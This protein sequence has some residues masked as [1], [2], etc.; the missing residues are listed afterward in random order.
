MKKEL[1]EKYFNNN[2][3]EEELK[4]VLDWFSTSAYLPEGKALLYNM[5]EEFDEQESGDKADFD[6]ILCKIHHEIN[7][8]QSK[9]LIDNSENDLVRY[10]RRQYFITL[11]R[12]VAAILLLPV[13]GLGLFYSV[14]YYSAKSIHKSVNVAFNE[15]FSSF[16]AITKV[17][18]PD[19][20]VVWLNHSSTLRYPAEFQ[21]G[22]RNVELKGEG[23]F[24]VAHNSKI[25]FIV[26]AGEIEIV[27]R[28]TTFNLLAYPEEDKIETSLINGVVEIRRMEDRG[29]YVSLLTMK[30][31][32]MAVYQDKTNEISTHTIT[33]DRYY[34]WKDG[35]LVFS[36]EPMSEVVKKLGRWFNA[37]IQTNDAELLDFPIS[38]TFVHETLPQ[39]LDLLTLIAP[40]NYSISDREALRDG[41]FSKRKIV[42]RYC[43][44]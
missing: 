7:I 39:V 21:V 27:A 13:L 34:S 31:T 33:D 44:R 11:I 20:S 37:D 29:R 38:A 8:R 14:R 30:P 32:D 4:L 43:K 2:C 35:K 23:Y 10:S 42:L 5:W 19:S 41:T 26:K 36:K 40:I 15:V 9:V 17:T 12:N 1:I 3:S 25:P 18:L 28:G 24:E 16:D 6:T 22:S